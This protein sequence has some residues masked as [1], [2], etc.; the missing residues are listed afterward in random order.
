MAVTSLATV[1]VSNSPIVAIVGD[2]AGDQSGASF[3]IYNNGPNTVYVGGSDVTSATGIPVPSTGR[4]N[5][6]LEAGET[7]YGVCASAETAVVRIAKQSS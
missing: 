1:A 5:W 2:G 4:L 6:A 3:T 7:L